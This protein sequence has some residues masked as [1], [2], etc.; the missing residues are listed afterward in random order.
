[1]SVS[2][3]AVPNIERYDRDGQLVEALRLRD[4]AAAE[5]LVTTYQSR[6]FRLALGI[7]G[8]A[9]DAEE[10]VQ[11]AFL[12]AIRKIHMFRG[13]SAFG[14]WL[15]RIVVN[16]AIQKTRCRRAERRNLTLDDVLPVFDG[17]GRHAVAVADWSG[18]VDNPSR[19]LEIQRAVRSAIAQLPV[20]YRAAFVMRDVE[21][22]SP[23]EVAEALGFSVAAVKMRTHRARLFVRQRLSEAL[24]ECC[25][26]PGALA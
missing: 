17:N 9:E 16:R 1:M 8:N 3:V 24:G 14:S 7:T 6:A 10:V 18:I 21:G 20:H 11:D 23:A 5:R 13:E 26:P 2:A 25:R 15:Y 12:V 22:A 4:T 19:R